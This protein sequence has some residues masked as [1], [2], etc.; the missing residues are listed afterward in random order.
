M[1]TSV[2]ETL[3]FV[4]AAF[5]ATAFVVGCSGDGGGG[6][7]AGKSMTIEVDPLQ[8]AFGMVL[9]NET[10]SRDI[11]ITNKGP[12]GPL[13]ITGVS[14]K[15]GSSADFSLGTVDKEY[16]EVDETAT[17]TVT[18]A[19]TDTER[20]TGFVVIEHNAPGTDA[21]QVTLTSLAQI[22]KLYFDPNPLLFGEIET[23]HSIDQN[24]RIING[25]AVAATLNALT[26]AP[27]GSE[28][29]GIIAEP[30]YPAS[31]EPGGET[32]VTIR[33]EPTEGGADQASLL[34]TYVQADSDETKTEELTVRGTEVAPDITV[35]PGVVDF[36]WVALND[37]QQAAVTIRNDGS[38]DLIISSI[39]LD[40]A[41]DAVTVEGLPEGEV[42]LEP[43]DTMGLLVHFNATESFPMTT[44]PIAGIHI[45][46]NDPDEGDL[47]TPVYARIEAPVI[48]VV[49]EDVVEFNVAA[50]NFTIR[51]EVVISNIGHAAL[52]VGSLSVAGGQGALADEFS[53]DG[54]N[55]TFP[56]V[57]ASGTG[58]IEPNG[59][60][61]IYVAFTNLGPDTGEVW[62]TLSIEHNDDTVST[63]I[64]VT[65]HAQRGGAPTC[66]VVLE[67]SLLNYGTVP[68]GA[69]KD[70]VMTLRNV[71][72]GN[73]SF[74]RADV[75]DCPVS[76]FPGLPAT[77]SQSTAS[78]E[79]RVT[80]APLPVQEGLQPGDTADITVRFEPPDGAPTL[81]E[82]DEYAG[83]LQVTMVSPYLPAGD[84][85]FTVPSEDNTSP[86][87]QGLSGISRISVLPDHVD[88]GLVTL[89]CVSELKTVTVYNSGTAPL[90][91][92]E[93]G[94][95][96]ECSAEFIISA[97]AIPP[98]GLEVTTAQPL[99]IEVR[100]QPQVVGESNC[101]LIIRSS[102]TSVP[103]ISVPMSGEGTTETHQIDIF[104][105]VAGQEVDIL[106]V[107]DDSGSMC[108]EQDRLAANFNSFIN[109]AQ[110]WG[111]S[112]HLGVVSTCVQEEDVC[113]GAGELKTKFWPPDRWID[114]DSSAHFTENVD[115]GCDGGSDSQE[116]G[117]EA[118]HLALS[119]PHIHMSTQSCGNDNDCQAPDMCIPW[120]GAGVCAGWNGGF[121]REDAA[122]EIVMLSDEEDQSTA[123][124]DFYV[125]FFK[126]I[127]G[128]ANE[129]FL[130]VH[131][132]VGDKGSG[133]GDPEGTETSAGA[134]DRYIYV[135]EQTNGI[136]ESICNDSFAD[137]LSQIGEL[138][139]GLKVQF[140]LS[141][142][143]DPS[144]I[145]VTVAGVECSSG[146]TYDPPSNSIIFDLDGLCMPDEGDE[147]RIEYDAIC[148]TL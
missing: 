87:L 36:G 106:F 123:P 60:V 107:I 125:D 98:D 38:E 71:G 30:T 99:E 78:P 53:I 17:V 130:H 108:E 64:E 76:L 79:F 81:F 27:N 100:Y 112:Y 45:V 4:L 95:S 96:Q 142:V 40:P 37:A 127:K 47:T 33:Y 28:D 145:T 12:D 121:L 137:A 6:I 103:V 19:P 120:E 24:V 35:T 68:H 23:A 92:T 44:D 113:E 5:V 63:P 111:N 31:I 50:Q 66:E 13:H 131:S 122:L 148:F 105:Q 49:P 75:Y 124:P 55:I 85:S 133:C 70:M 119:L 114:N 126:S 73:C 14:L 48:R 62:G 26:W 72:S 141:R 32:S 97:P 39:T 3:S 25:G 102:D 115:I 116:A 140:F 41:H 139:F 57:T 80:A 29:F 135:S 101:S 8:V 94:P 89:G 128:F 21:V 117:L 136:V 129:N 132:I 91:V 86:N 2:R 109:H 110:T 65:L 56:P 59:S 58:T 146:W 7:T 20:D 15:A 74:L 34:A 144:T 52:E 16:L 143:G 147:I 83:L 138:A 67:P 1:R 43:E 134:G 54:S 82:M 93:I 77:C 104:E 61:T 84:N 10:D 42:V 18:Y 22:S 9:V 69:T 90:F 51:R 46:S 88:F 11:H 118:A